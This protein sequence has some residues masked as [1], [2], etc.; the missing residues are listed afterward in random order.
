M[1]IG[2]IDPDCFSLYISA[3]FRV[4]GSSRTN[5]CRIIKFMDGQR[6]NPQVYSEAVSNLTS[7]KYGID[8]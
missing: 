7:L 4:V 1:C 8:C 6:M 2:Y 5:A 3:M